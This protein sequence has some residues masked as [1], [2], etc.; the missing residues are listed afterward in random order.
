M[1]ASI[2]FEKVLSGIETQYPIHPSDNLVLLQK[3]FKSREFLY[4]EILMTSR[5]KF[6]SED[7]FR[8]QYDNK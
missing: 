5:E 3:K 4:L 2:G 8:V 6:N 1:F 7:T